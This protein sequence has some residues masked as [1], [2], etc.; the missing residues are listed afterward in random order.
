MDPA[1]LLNQPASPQRP[2]EMLSQSGSENSLNFTC[3]FK[4]GPS[5]PQQSAEEDYSVSVDGESVSVIIPA[6]CSVYQLRLRICM[7]VGKPPP[8]G[9]LFEKCA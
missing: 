3:E 2:S 5:P 9:L 4:T 8:D 1:S 6:Q 7:Q